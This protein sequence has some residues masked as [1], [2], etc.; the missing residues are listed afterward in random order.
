MASTN[1]LEPV[2]E[3]LSLNVLHHNVPVISIGKMFVDARKALMS[4]L[5]EIRNL[6]IIRIGCLDHL[7]CAKPTQTDTLYG[8]KPVSLSSILRLVDLGKTTLTNQAE[9]AIALGK[10]ETTMQSSTSGSL[11]GKESCF[12]R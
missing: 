5:R 9:D 7:T 12:C 3:C 1:R 8:Y 2:F 6:A 10:Q 11:R 4:Q